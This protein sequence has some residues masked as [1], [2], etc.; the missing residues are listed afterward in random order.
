[1]ISRDDL[2]NFIDRLSAQGV[3]AKEVE[4]GNWQPLLIGR[5]SSLEDRLADDEKE[6]CAKRNGATFIHVHSTRGSEFTRTA[7]EAD[8]IAKWN[9]M[10]NG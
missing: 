4:P 7:E 5:T 10:C 3:H 6:A 2:E 8:L 9:P 1:M